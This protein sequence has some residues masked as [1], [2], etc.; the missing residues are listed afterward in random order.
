VLRYILAWCSLLCGF[1]GFFYALLN[2]ERL[3]LHD[4]ILGTRIIFDETSAS[5]NRKGD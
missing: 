3:F 4:K 1:M 2:K 5:Y